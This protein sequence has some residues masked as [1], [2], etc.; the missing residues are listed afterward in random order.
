MTIENCINACRSHGYDFAGLEYSQECYCDD[1]IKNSG[2]CISQTKC[3]MH[4]SGNS[5]ELCGGSN[6]L[7]V[8]QYD[9]WNAAVNSCCGIPASS[10]GVIQNG[11][12]EN[13]L[14]PWNVNPITPGSAQ[15]SV[16]GADGAYSGCSNLIIRAVNRGSQNNNAVSISQTISGLAINQQYT[17]SM[18]T[19]WNTLN[20]NSG[21]SVL[22]KVGLATGEL[23]MN[24]APC[25][26]SQCINKGQGGISAYGFMGYSVITPRSSTVQ[27]YI[28]VTWTGQ[29]NGWDLLI[30]GVT[31]TPGGIPGY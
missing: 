30:D 20:Y 12:F 16:S 10:S 29:M 19:G 23:L 5:A 25:G 4:C 31:L 27:L 15:V 17:F 24:E 2:I 21:Q 26:G 22:I 14:S 9:R 6:A 1:F 18:Y 13:G 28:N 8:Y 11:N 3:N 7:N